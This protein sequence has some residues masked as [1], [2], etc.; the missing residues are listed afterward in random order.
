MLDMS[1]V[2][3]S[4]EFL[5]T[6]AI[7][8]GT[9]TITG[10]RGANSYGS[11]ATVKAIVMPVARRLIQGSDGALRDGAIEIYTL[12]VISGGVKTNDASSRLPDQVTWH[13]ALYEVQDV[14]D[15]S[16]WG[17]GWRRATA[18]LSLLNPTT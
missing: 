3:L 14:T 11:P 4:P 17:A 16:S 2:L 15:W 18:N 8:Q 1:D 9:Q 13:G 7:A 10:G 12:A 6:V 5:E